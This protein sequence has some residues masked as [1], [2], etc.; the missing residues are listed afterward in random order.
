[1]T[2]LGVRTQLAIGQLQLQEAAVV[3]LTQQYYEVR[4][5]GPG[6]IS[7]VSQLA[8]NVR[9]LE[10]WLARPENADP[11]KH[12]EVAGMI[13]QRKIDL[14]GLTTAELQRSAREVELATQLQAAQNRLSDS[15]D[16]I[17][18]MERALDVA[19]QQISKPK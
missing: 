5:N 13:R 19:I 12:E 7:R 8:E 17:A 11:R 14:E 9:S 16:R 4:S 1:M 15:R 6:A 18:E 2:L 10:Q 3:R